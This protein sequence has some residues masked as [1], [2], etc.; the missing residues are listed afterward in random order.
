MVAAKKIL[1]DNP[2]SISEELRFIQGTHNGILNPADVVEYAKNSNT[3][4]HN[5]FTWDNTEAARLYRIEQARHIIRLELVI[6]EAPKKFGGNI[7]FSINHD[8]PSGMPVRA[9][10][11]L[12]KDRHSEGG[13]RSIDKVMEN[14]EMKASLLEEAKKDMIRF[15]QKYAILSKLARVFRAMD[16]II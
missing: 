3:L 6:A 2:K 9:F 11:S 14:D 10:V 5:R 13:Y 12:P 8:N 16:E 4:L 15:K 7:T 1:A